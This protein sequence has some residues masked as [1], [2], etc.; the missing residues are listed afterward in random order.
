MSEVSEAPAT[1]L[2]EAALG[3]VRHLQQAGFAAYWVGGCVRDFLLGR[4]PGDYDIV[5]AA[6]PD[7]IEQAFPHT[8]PVGRQFGVILVLEAGHQFQVATFRAEGDY[9]DGRRPERVTFGDAR[10]DAARRDFTVNGLFYDPVAEKL[11]DWVGGEADL[12]AKIIRTIGLPA[13]RFDE[14]YLRLLRAVRLAA[15]LNFRL[16]TQTLSALQAGASKIKAISAERIRDELI[17]LFRPPH[18][19]RGLDLLQMSGLLQHVLPA[20]AATVGCAQSP[21]FHPEG[22]VFNHLRLMLDQ[23]PAEAVPALPW[24]ILLHDVAKPVTASTDPATGSI[25][26]YGHEKIG[27]QMATEILEGLRFPRRQ[28]EDIVQAV[29]C[30]MQFKDALQMRKATLRRLIL[31]PTFPLELELHRLDCLG[32]HGRLDVY[33][34]LVEQAD[35]LERQPQIRPPLLNGTDLIALG[36]KPGPALGALLAEAREKQL[37]D[38]LT[39]PEE[40]RAWAK[41]RLSAEASSKPPRPLPPGDN[42]AC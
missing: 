2:R 24:A 36:L 16:E 29:R 35:A 11:Y 13:E 5:T 1:P 7:Q 37:E 17:R 32:S 22:S 23:M 10:A 14:D 4:P 21:D 20:I 42:S 19:A 41:R 25:H 12:R 9:Q 30:H 27:A 18:A 33:G 38:Q 6:L 28:I 3:I 34:F 26:F 31:R 39:T 40:A 8:V 15:Q